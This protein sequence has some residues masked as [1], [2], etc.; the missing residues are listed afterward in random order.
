ML[1]PNPKPRGQVGVG[2][3]IQF[4]CS[5]KVAVLFKELRAKLDRLLMD[6][7]EQP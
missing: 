1:F 6:K 5:A 2:K 7:I 4:S 3:W